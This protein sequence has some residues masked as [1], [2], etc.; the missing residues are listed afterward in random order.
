MKQPYLLPLLAALASCT[1]E[2][3]TVNLGIDDVYRIPRMQ[4]LPLS[5]AFTG[6]SYLW[7]IDGKPVSTSRDY[8]FL[9]A[10][11]GTY[12]VS[13][14][15]IDT[16]TPYSYTFQVIVTEEEVAYSPY[17]A[18]VNEY[19]PAPGQFINEMPQYEDGNTYASMLTKAEESI[20]GTNDVMISLGGFGGYV[21]FSFDHTVINTPGEA[22]FRIWG[23]SIYQHV[24][25]SDERKGGSA[26]PGIVMVSLDVNCN[27]IPDDPWYELI[28]SEHN[29][30]STRKGYAITYHRPDPDREIEGDKSG[31]V[32][33]VN[34]MAWNDNTGE[35]GYIPKNNFHRQEYYPQWLSDDKLTF[36]GTLLPPNA[37]DLS[38]K[39]SNYIHFCYA[40]GYADNH[41][42]DEAAL[43]S[44]DIGNAV[45]S[46]G[47][48]VMLPGADFIRV[49]TG[50]NQICG[51][52][53]ET[54][55][56][57]CR[58]ADLHIIP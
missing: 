11:P 47:I 8:I 17:I 7:S 23:N 55:T 22:D 58:A 34:Y 10:E 25:T 53:G 50:V 24:N 14:D 2:T 19:C 6:E 45:D 40:W 18:H 49:Y 12:T 43:N 51:W 46:Y 13:L 38:G 56:E 3:P 54:S 5:P 30:P 48:P 20:S 36:T 52:L 42:N 28:G 57:I 32:T 16:T 27:G 44:F 33:D 21:T 1:S 29:N 35:G 31:L 39:G 37:E 4:K 9:E 41:P 26:E 15:I